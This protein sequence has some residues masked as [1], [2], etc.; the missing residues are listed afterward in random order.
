[1][2]AMRKGVKSLFENENYWKQLVNLV[3][4]RERGLFCCDELTDN[5]YIMYRKKWFT[6]FYRLT[7]K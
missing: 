2:S 3:D 7:L 1:M 6:F 4:L 5:A